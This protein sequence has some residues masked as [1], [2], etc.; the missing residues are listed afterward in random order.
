MVKV[1]AGSR[2]GKS[3][4]TL[5]GLETR[6]TANRVREA[7]FNIIQFD[8]PGSAVLDLF[9]GSGA[10]AIESLSRGASRAVLCDASRQAA[11]VICANLKSCAF[12]AELFRG[13]FRV[14]LRTLIN[15]KDCFDIVFLDP[16]Y[17]MAEERRL[18]IESIFEGNLLEENGYLVVETE[19]GQE[20]EIPDC[21]EVF[22]ER[23]Y[24]KTKLSRV[25]RRSLS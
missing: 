20:V 16:P 17:V 15:R 5:E 10:L 6:P 21:A 23:R 2:R 12:E 14:C 4:Q 25:R 7:L 11:D 8:L 9:A 19:V 22:D 18:S 24:G 1:I 3:L 13:D